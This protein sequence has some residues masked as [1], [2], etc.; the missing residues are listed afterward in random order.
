MI[1]PITS[2]RMFAYKGGL[3]SSKEEI[4]SHHGRRKRKLWASTGCVSFGRMTINDG[5]MLCRR[6]LVW[7][8]A[9][10]TFHGYE[11]NIC[12]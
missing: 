10:R 2:W 7:W 12:G 4:C 8:K 9:K 6:V 11:A 3:S 1:Q 5:I